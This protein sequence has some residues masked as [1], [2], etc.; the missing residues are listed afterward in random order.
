MKQAI[1]SIVVPIAL[2]LAMVGTFGPL[3]MA[4]QQEAT[5]VVA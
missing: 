2:F 4:G 3:A 5:F 1:L